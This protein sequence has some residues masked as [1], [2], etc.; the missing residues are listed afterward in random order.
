MTEIVYPVWHQRLAKSLH[1]NN[2]QVQ[3][4]YYQ[5]ASVSSNGD[6]KNRTMVF[7]GFLSGTQSLLSVTDS[8]SEKI[9]QWQGDNKSRFE[10]CWYFAGSREQFRL[11]GEVALISHSIDSNYGNW[12]LGEHT[13]HNLLK[14]QWS[15]LSTNAKQPFYSNSPKAPFD[16]DAIQSFPQDGLVN[17][18]NDINDEFDSRSNNNSAPRNIAGHYTD[19]S[20]NFCVVVFIPHAVD[21]LN[22]KSKPQQRC[23]Y[24]IQDDWKERT[25]NP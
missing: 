14:Q 4:K 11:A 25:V 8:R 18:G 16:E 17:Q 1:V 6:P 2:S 13:K 22:L 3:S 15:N 12:V 19:I 21:Y 7:R 5:V 23:L 9:E 20:D 10:I 24:D